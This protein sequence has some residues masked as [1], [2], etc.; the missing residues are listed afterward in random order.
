MPLYA[1]RVGL[2]LIF[3]NLHPLAPRGIELL[4]PQDK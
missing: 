2:L 3:P 4:K 1:W